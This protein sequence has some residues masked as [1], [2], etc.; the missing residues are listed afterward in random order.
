MAI[1]DAS[2]VQARYPQVGSDPDTDTL[3]TAITLAQ[4]IAETWCG[5]TFDSE[6]VTEYHDAYYHEREIYLHKRNI[7]T[8][9]TF[10]VYYDRGWTWGSSSAL[11]S[12]SYNLDSENGVL[13]LLSDYTP[14][15][16][17]WK[18]TYIGG[19]SSAPD[20]LKGA[21]AMI[22]VALYSRAQTGGVGVEGD[23]VGEGNVRQYV[24]LLTQDVKVALAKYRRVAY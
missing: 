7:D 23:V 18:I 1:I 5:I 22:A 16:R 20:D 12:D 4:Q 17:A 21:V 19:W 6:A 10:A 8:G 24:S 13:Y 11:D 14:G 3:G 15:P 9:E 2:Y